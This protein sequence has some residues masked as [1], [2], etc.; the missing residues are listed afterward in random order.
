MTFIGILQHELRIKNELTINDILKLCMR[1][2]HYQDTA[3]RVLEPDKTPFAKKVK[4]K[5]IEKWVYIPE[6]D[7]N[8]ICI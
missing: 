8:N 2:N 6:L 1:Y 7:D 5:H 4:S 3:R